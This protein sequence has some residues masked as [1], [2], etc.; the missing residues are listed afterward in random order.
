MFL[1]QHCFIVALGERTIAA[2]QMSMG[3]TLRSIIRF[4]GCW[5]RGLGL[6]SLFTS[7]MNSGNCLGW[8][9]FGGGSCYYLTGVFWFL[10]AHK[11][12]MVE[13]NKIGICWD[14]PIIKYEN[15]NL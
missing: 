10:Q 2:I 13:R 9:C 6:V 4:C 5:F 3:A 7:E 8:K 15:E 11:M 14:L 1:D 12:S